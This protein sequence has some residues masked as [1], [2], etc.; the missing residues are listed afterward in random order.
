MEAAVSDLSD[1]ARTFIAATRHGDDPR[2][3][4]QDRVHRAVMVRIGMG[5]IAGVA[6]VSVGRDAVAAGAAKAGWASILGPSVVKLMAILT[7]GGSVTVGGYLALHREPAAPLSDTPAAAP[8]LPASESE[9]H[10]AATVSVP[11]RE[12]TPSLAADD[13]P[14]AS[15]DPVAAPEPSVPSTTSHRGSTLRAEV[16]AVGAANRSLRDGNPQEALRILDTNASVLQDGTLRE[17]AAASRILALCQLGRREQ[18][19]REANAFVQAFPNSPLAGRV[20]ASCAF[21]PRGTTVP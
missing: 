15:S 2:P 6:A 8:D 13:L 3:A 19:T 17:E 14:V 7:V 20:R 5:T 4:D 9:P 11:A 18:A 1:D 12:A 10:T 21:A 16:A